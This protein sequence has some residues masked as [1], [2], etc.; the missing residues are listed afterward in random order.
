MKILYL[1][2]THIT[3]KTPSSR[4]D[5]IQDTIK[6]KFKEIGDIIKDESIEAVVHG[7][8]MFHIPEVSNKF[9]GEVSK[10][11]RKYNVPF[12]VVPGNHDLQGQNE[13]SLP[14]TKLG[15]LVN[16][17]V[18]NLLDRKHPV[19]FDENGYKISFEGQE[20]HP[21][22][23]KEPLKDYQVINTYADF[24]VLVAHSMLLERDYH[25]GTV[26]TLI[27]NVQT[28]ADLILGAHYHP[29][30]KP[31]LVNGTWF[32]NP[33][34]LV[35]VE[36]STHS[37]K[38]AKPKVAI[39]DI[40]SNGFNQKEV[41]LT[42]AVEGTKVFSTKNLEKKGYGQTIAN[43]NAKLRNVKL[44]DVNIVSMIDEYVKANPE[45]IKIVTKSKDEIVKIQREQV[46]D[47]GYVPAKSNVAIDKVEI[48]NFQAHENLSVDFVKGINT[49]VGESNAG[50][51]A[52]MRAIRFAF[53]NKPSGSDFITTGKKSC[54]VK[55][56]LSNGF[57][58]ER[59]RSRSAAGSYILTRP[60]GTSQEYKG[61]KNNIPIDII[62]AHQMPELKIGGNSYSLNISTQ[63]EPAFMVSAGSQ[64]RMSLIGALVDT[65]RADAAKKVI[66]SEKRTLSLS[67]KKT[68]E[69]REKEVAKLSKYDKLDSMKLSVETL[70]MIDEKLD[71]DEQKLVTLNDAS[72]SY[73]K[74]KLDI[75]NIDNRLSSI[76]LVDRDLIDNF[77]SE[78]TQAENLQALV[79]L[80]KGS[81]FNLSQINHKLDIIPKLISN[82]DIAEYNNLL[83]K[84]R[85]LQELKVTYDKLKD[86]LG[87]IA[88]SLNAMPELVSNEDIETYKN[89]CTELQSMIS[90]SNEYKDLSSKNFDFKVD[91]ES[92]KKLRDE[93]VDTMKLISEIMNCNGEY[94][95]VNKSLGLISTQ[96][97]ELENHITINNHKK[98]EKL[99]MLKGQTHVCEL[100]G[101]EVSAEKLIVA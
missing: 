45:D 15:L 81:V 53:H 39:L 4:L 48:K 6:A 3:A 36:G 46:V 98:Q 95:T 26:Y 22:I 85:E 49:I 86:T 58:I 31:Q 82:K 97:E 68:E 54:S 64:E 17:G 101:S 93:Y 75:V 80:Y 34:S 69:D 72:N 91:L 47:N 21:H 35:R 5:D 83:D 60:D 1:T 41:E 32:I 20:Y 13:D 37:I 14:H 70:E 90:L 2:D 11:I 9:V 71:N 18:V 29:G 19:I 40:S 74:L 25:E 8:D 16:T 92:F 52:I 51:T 23:D 73:N 59:K 63:L 87:N 27:K 55:V 38:T 44:D 65:D 42:C 62:N 28:K 89:I 79:T 96:I 66:A 78:L 56:H 57:I 94:S 43:F 7:G 61:F 88:S 84:V 50:K 67:I 30:Y 99:D 12:Y 77:N 10:I 100:C 33:G 76:E 24:K